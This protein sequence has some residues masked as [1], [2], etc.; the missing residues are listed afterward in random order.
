MKRRRLLFA[1]RNEPAV[2]FIV[3]PMTSI[4]FRASSVPPLM[5]SVPLCLICILVDA[6]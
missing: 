1:R 6:E 5:F 2:W 4:L 3:P